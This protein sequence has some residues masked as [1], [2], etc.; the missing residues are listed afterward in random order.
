MERRFLLAALLALTQ[1]AAAATIAEP[2]A[3]LASLDDEQ[4]GAASRALLA[5]HHIFIRSFSKRHRL[6]RVALTSDTLLVC[7]CSAASP[8]PFG[9]D[10]MRI[11]TPDC[12][13]CVKA[14]LG[15]TIQ[16]AQISAMKI[17]APLSLVTWYLFK[18]RPFSMIPLEKALGKVFGVHPAIYAGAASGAY[19]SCRKKCDL[20]C[21]F[22]GHD[23]RPDY[24]PEL[25]SI[26]A[27]DARF[28]SRLYQRGGGGGA[29]KGGFASAL[30]QMFSV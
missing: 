5:R 4:S 26:D 28:L 14:C 8:A 9:I 12:V 24:L 7:R 30:G 15:G 10:A 27:S 19:L 2:G 3:Q 1:P 6:M 16:Q 13:R 21:P 18:N 29:K 17:Q 23:E 22:P 11:T 25:D 20:D